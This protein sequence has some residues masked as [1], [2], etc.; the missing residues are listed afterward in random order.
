MFA[1]MEEDALKEDGVSGANVLEDSKDRGASKR[2]DHFGA[3]D[4]LGIPHLSFAR[5][6]TCQLSS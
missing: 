5:I 3:K 4:G 2:P 6:P 1:I